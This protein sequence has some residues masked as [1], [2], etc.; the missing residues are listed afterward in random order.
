MS[1]QN[2]NDD[3]EDCLDHV[4][5]VIDFEGDVANDNDVDP[6][7]AEYDYDYESDPDFG[8]YSIANDDGVD[9]DEGDWDFGLLSEWDHD[10]ED[11][12]RRSDKRLARNFLKLQRSALGRGVGR[13]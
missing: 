10:W 12:V 5:L 7:E 11:D 3:Y 2:D 8:P 6:D 1:P 4:C 13:R 9:C